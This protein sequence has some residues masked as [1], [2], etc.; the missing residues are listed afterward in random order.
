MGQVTVNVKHDLTLYDDAA[1]LSVTACPYRKHAVIEIVTE[2]AHLTG[3]ADLDAVR[4]LR[5]MLADA[6]LVMMGWHQEPKTEEL[7]RGERQEWE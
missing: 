6:E 5:Q 7:T 4:R 3:E 2:H 1:R